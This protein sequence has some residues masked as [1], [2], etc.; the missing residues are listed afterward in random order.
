LPDFEASR[1][2]SFDGPPA[3]PAFV[4]AAA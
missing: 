3:P 4:E 2:L 1:L